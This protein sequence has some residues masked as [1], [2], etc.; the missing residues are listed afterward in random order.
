MPTLAKLS[1]ALFSNPIGAV[2]DGSL[3]AL[4][5]LAHPRFNVGE[6]RRGG[7]YENAEEDALLADLAAARGVDMQELKEKRAE[8]A[9][10]EGGD[11]T[12]AAPLPA[13]DF[14]VVSFG[15]GAAATPAH[16]P[17]RR[18]ARRGWVRDQLLPSLRVKQKR[19]LV[20][21]QA[22]DEDSG[23]WFRRKLKESIKASVGA[24]DFSSLALSS[25]KSRDPSSRGRP[26]SF[27]LGG[28]DRLR[29]AALEAVDGIEKKAGNELIHDGCF[30]LLLE[31]LA[32]NKDIV[33]VEPGFS[34]AQPLNSRITKIIQD[35]TN[36]KASMTRATPIWG[37]SSLHFNR[38]FQPSIT[39]QPPSDPFLLPVSLTA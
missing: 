10:M 17:A 14:L 4:S 38:F 32:E 35:S 16:D 12:T 9:E 19:A 37:K 21:A 7:D 28:L 15:R 18:P 3:T 2:E 26:A 6:V 25:R 30:S 11:L 22:D 31:A 24:C 29:T 8:E 39:R 23:L 27:R 1:D 33:Y 20:S 13:E 34:H 36:A 5:S